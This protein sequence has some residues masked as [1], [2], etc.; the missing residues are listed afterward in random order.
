MH[1]AIKQAV[2]I[3]IANCHSCTY[4]GDVGDGYEYNGSILACEN[5]DKKNIDNL[6]GFPFQ[7]EQKCWTPEFWHSKFAGMIKKGDHD[8]VLAL[9]GEFHAAVQAATVASPPS[10]KCRKCDKDSGIAH[11]P[12]YTKKLK[13][14]GWEYRQNKHGV[15]IYC[16]ECAEAVW[17]DPAVVAAFQALTKGPR[18]NQ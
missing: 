5:P 16:K 1:E 18:V 10:V 13:A 15:R 9:Q 7:S 17:N 11:A 14:V 6:P 3:N 8:E 4:L 12:G 2:G